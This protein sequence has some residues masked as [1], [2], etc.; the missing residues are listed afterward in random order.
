MCF[1][2]D[3][4]I[5]V[6][7]PVPEGVAQTPAEFFAAHNEQSGRRLQVI[8]G[9]LGFVPGSVQQFFDSCKIAL[10][11][12]QVYAPIALVHAE[13][14]INKG[15]EAFVHSGGRAVSFSFSFKS[16]FSF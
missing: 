2:R 6:C 9:E 7:G 12:Y 3:E 13:K 5:D 10:V 4:T 16:F 8:E 11:R 1:L 14:E 15:M